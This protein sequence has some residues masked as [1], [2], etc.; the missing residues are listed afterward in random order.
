M[1]EQRDRR[2]GGRGGWVAEQERRPGG[3]EDES[4]DDAEDAEHAAR[5]GRRCGLED[6]HALSLYTVALEEVSGAA[7]A[8]GVREQRG[9]PRL[10]AVA[11]DRDAEGL[12]PV[13]ERRPGEE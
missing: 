13:A 6:R 2:H 8:G 9:S 5:P 12:A 10:C 1:R 7:Q 4:G 11:R 3:D